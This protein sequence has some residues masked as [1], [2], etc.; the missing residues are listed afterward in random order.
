MPLESGQKTTVLE[1]SVFRHKTKSVTC[2][3]LRSIR[4]QPVD[5]L[6]IYVKASRST[7]AA[8]SRLS[9]TRSRWAKMICTP[10]Y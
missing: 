5:Q 4:I 3:R 10:V 2:S 6:R 1:E 8:Q 7:Q 9:Y